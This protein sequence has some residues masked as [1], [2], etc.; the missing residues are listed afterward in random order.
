MSKRQVAMVMDLN[1][2]LGCQTCTV[3]CKR[4]WTKRDGMAH[5]WWNTVNTQPGSGTPHGFE[6]MGGGFRDGVAQ[7]GHRPSVEEFGKAWTF[8]HQEVAFGG[9]PDAS[10]VAD[11]G[12]AGKGPNW[13]EDVGGGEYPNSH[14][15]YLPR[16][17]NHCTHPACL[18]ACPRQA[19]KKREEDGIVLI[20]EDH[21]RG[22]RFCQEACPYKKIYYNEVAGVSQKCIFCFPRIDAGV[23]TA[24]S[25]QCP[26]RV[27]FVGYL[28]D[29]DGPIHKLVHQHKVALPLHAEYGTQPNVFYVPPLSPPQL[30]ADGDPTEVPRIPTEYLVSLFGPRVVEVLEKIKHER[31]RVQRGE[32]SE[33]M[34]LLIS[35]KWLDM[36][37]PFTKHPR[38]VAQEAQATQSPVK[39]YRKGART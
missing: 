22:H 4:L 20:D 12:H 24:C 7:P 35:R 38:E 26:G 31:E 9:D 3:A 6:S 30:D 19:I 18:E 23:T 39:F 33:L 11:G 27:R 15:F 13:D 28:D 32:T 10:L 17:C 34:D 29:P 8:N 1:K 36:F 21:C 2:C 16:I 14:Y 37:G 5:M 25:R